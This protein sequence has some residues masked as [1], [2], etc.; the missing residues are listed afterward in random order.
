MSK[1]GRFPYPQVQ[2]KRVVHRNYKEN[3]L[4]KFL[5]YAK[6][7]ILKKKGKVKKK[8]FRKQFYLKHMKK[9]RHMKKKTLRKTIAGFRSIEVQTTV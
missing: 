1:L 9:K 6:G 3:F 2:E 4:E 7:M 5:M 8:S